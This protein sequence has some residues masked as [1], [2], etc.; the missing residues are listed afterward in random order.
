MA[1]SRAGR[2]LQLEAGAA[3]G[4]IGS[5]DRAAQLVDDLVADREAEAGALA[6]LLGG[7]KRIEDASQVLRRNARTGVANRKRDPC[8]VDARTRV[9]LPAR[10]SPALRSGKY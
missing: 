4:V 5:A 6:G 8:A 1:L 3:A 10:P 9:D 7:E 2:Q